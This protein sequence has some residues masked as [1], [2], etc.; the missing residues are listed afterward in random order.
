L[1]GNLLNT[2]NQD[3][4]SQDTGDGPQKSRRLYKKDFI[5]H[6]YYAGTPI[7]RVYSDDLWFLTDILTKDQCSYAKIHGCWQSKNFD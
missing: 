6:F 2:S 3:T 7:I 1:D 4:G 5:N